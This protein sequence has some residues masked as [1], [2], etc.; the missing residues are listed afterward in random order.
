MTAPAPSAPAP[1]PHPLAHVVL[2]E[3][4]IPNN[5]GNI[6]RTCVVTGCHMHLVGPL[7]FDTDEKAYRRAG[8][9]YWPRL[10][11]TEHEHLAAYHAA[12][13]PATTRRW[14]LSSKAETS[15]YDADLQPGDHLLLGRESAGLPASLTEAA[16]D[17][18]I[19]LPMRARERSLN[20]A[21][22]AAVVIYEMLRRAIATGQR[23]PGKD[24]RF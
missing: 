9:D 5:A 2:V 6:G 3:P 13:P 20:Q 18:C 15:V 23:T 7:G 11:L 1:D 14:L 10:M 17:H 19:S 8:L 24:N 12:H 16:P 22:C 4:E 21:S